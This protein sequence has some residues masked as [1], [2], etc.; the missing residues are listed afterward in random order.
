MPANLRLHQLGAG[1][2]V[3]EIIP[4]Q[5]SDSDVIVYTRAALAALL[6]FP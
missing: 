3:E 5:S 4:G 2:I 1:P 6:W